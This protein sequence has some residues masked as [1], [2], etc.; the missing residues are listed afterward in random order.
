MKK[1]LALAAFVLSLDL[2]SKFLCAKFLS[3]MTSVDYPFGGVPLFQGGGITASLNQARNSGAAWGM[4]QG[5]P[6]FLAVA[7]FA[8][9]AFLL[10]SKHLNLASM[11]VAV[12]ALG[13]GIDYFLYG[14]VVDFVYFTFWGY[15]FPVFNLADCCITI[16]AFL[17]LFGYRRTS[18][19]A[20]L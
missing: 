18:K 11:L 8:A 1:F 6:G 3:P 12:G 10:C 20:S 13:N 9:A 14:Q 4:L 16:G 7:R 2:F 19:A 17:M 15:S 5:F